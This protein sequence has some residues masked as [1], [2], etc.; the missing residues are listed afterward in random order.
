M[1]VIRKTWRYTTFDKMRTEFTTLR[2][3]I[4]VTEISP[5]ALRMARLSPVVRA[6]TKE[7][8]ALLDGRVVFELPSSDFAQLLRGE[9][10]P[11]WQVF[12]NL[13][14][15]NVNNGYVCISIVR[16]GDGFEVLLQKPPDLLGADVMAAMRGDTGYDGDCGWMPKEETFHQVVGMTRIINMHM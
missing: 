9:L 14:G 12:P 13:R 3:V 15:L 6:L 1:D 2:E 16:R 8:D 7:F 11:A 5:R 4:P 10:S